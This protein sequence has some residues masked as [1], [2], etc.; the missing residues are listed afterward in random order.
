MRYLRV[1]LLQDGEDAS[2]VKQRIEL[3]GG[4]GGMV[5]NMK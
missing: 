4:P 1:R 2:A 5:T 3:D